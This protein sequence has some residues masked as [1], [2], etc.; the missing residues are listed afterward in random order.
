MSQHLQ[1]ISLKFIPQDK[2]KRFNS[3][4][5]LL[6]SGAF[7]LGPALAGLLFIIGSPIFAIYTNSFT[8]L[9][10]A[11]I[12]YLLPK[13]ESEK[14][15]TVKEKISFR[16]LLKDWKLVIGYAK[17]EYIM[18][19]YLLFQSVM[20]VCMALDSQEVIFTREVLHLSESSYGVLVSIGGVGILGG[21]LIN[22]VKVKRL[23]SQFLIGV[24]T[25]L[26]ACGYLIYSFSTSFMSGALGFFVLAFFSG[27]ANTGFWT[28]YQN[29]IPVNMMGR[30]GSVLGMFLA[31]L[32][33]GF[34]ALIGFTGDFISVKYVVIFGSSTMF[35]IALIL[36]LISSM[37]SK[38]NYF[39]R[40]T[41]VKAETT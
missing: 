7:V 10:S 5:S 4:R 38:V 32:Q 12:I 23:S 13:L 3:V 9:F 17:R 29:N 16:V 14:V 35:I 28:F 33:I 39:N 27:F 30:V 34:T 31:V 11:F 2:R 15:K 19:V 36:L 40:E 8:F 41:S 24:G 20:V 37:P 26:E 21:S 18:V 1:S 6:S 25:T 22:A